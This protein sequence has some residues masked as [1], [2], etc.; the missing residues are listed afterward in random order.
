MTD[1]DDMTREELYASRFRRRWGFPFPQEADSNVQNWA[2]AFEL[3]YDTLSD[4]LLAVAKSHRVT[5]AEGDNLGRIGRMFGPLGKRRT[6]GDGEYRRFLQSLIDTFNGRGTKE[7]IKF[8]TAA[9][10]GA[11]EIDDVTVTEHDA[12]NQYSL[13]ITNWGFH[14]AT[15]IRELA[16][17]ADPAAI[18][19]RE[20]VH[21]RYTGDKVGALKG[22]RRVESFAVESGVLGASTNSRQVE[23][24]TGD[25]FDGQD[26]FGDGDEFGPA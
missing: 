12:V 4:D 25:R 3:S 15:D 22:F 19:L 23:F 5:D 6:R 8:A 26:D 20:P 24:G 18:T 10:T 16:N 21:Y 7:G 13:E 2:L 14:S 17:L 9:G 1:P 11:G